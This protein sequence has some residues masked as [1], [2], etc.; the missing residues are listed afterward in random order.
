MEE[1]RAVVLAAQNGAKI[2]YVDFYAVWAGATQ[3]IYQWESLNWEVN[4]SP[5]WRNKDSQLLLAIAR[6]TLFKMGW[7]KT[8]AKDYQAAQSGIKR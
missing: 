1:I 3:W 5:V 2:I 8:Q 6:K 4:R 7:V